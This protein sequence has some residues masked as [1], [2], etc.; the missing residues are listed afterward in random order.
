MGGGLGGVWPR[1]GKLGLDVAL[2]LRPLELGGPFGVTLSWARCESWT[3]LP[4][5]GPAL[6]WV[7]GCQSLGD[8]PSVLQLLLGEPQTPA[9][10]SLDD[11]LL[12]LTPLPS[13]SR[14]LMKG[15]GWS[16]ICIASSVFVPLT[17]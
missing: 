12:V 5:E 2:L 7:G 15:P 16:N 8:E 13:V 14:E 3:G 4:T 6:G 9:L 1:E 10:T 11:R 17:V